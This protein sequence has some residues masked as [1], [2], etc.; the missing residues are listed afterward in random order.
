MVA[1]AGRQFPDDPNRQRVPKASFR[2]LRNRRV[3]RERRWTDIPLSP[4][5][6]IRADTN[7][8][9]HLGPVCDTDACGRPTAG[10]NSVKMQVSC[11]FQSRLR[12]LLI[13]V[14]LLAVAC[15][16]VAGTK[17]LRA[18]G[19]VRLVVRPVPP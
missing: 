9:G 2:Q 18:A 19:H 17:S 15:A 8:N 14:T 12:T 6:Y 13:V 1:K 10:N 16:Y 7:A 11:R 5:T 4:R 3:C